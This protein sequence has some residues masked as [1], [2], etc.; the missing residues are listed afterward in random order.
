MM[1]AQEVSSFLVDEFPGLGLSARLERSVQVARGLV[2]AE[3]IDP[4]A[5]QS[6]L[7]DIDSDVELAAKGESKEQRDSW[8][9]WCVAARAAGSRGF[10]KITAVRQVRA[11]TI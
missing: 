10:H 5:L 1:L 11:A 3:E 9:D 7:D 2:N 8:H 6:F 4:E